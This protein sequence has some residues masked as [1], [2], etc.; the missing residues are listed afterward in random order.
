MYSDIKGEINIVDEM[1][2]KV[3]KIYENIE[4]NKRTQSKISEN[5]ITLNIKEIKSTSLM[6]FCKSAINILNTKN[7]KTFR[8]KKKK[9][10]PIK[11]NIVEWVYDINSYYDILSFLGEIEPNK[12]NKKS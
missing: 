9:W 5:I 3:L 2:I 10:I 4:I 6:N 11:G 1:Y 12:F 8:L 7:Q